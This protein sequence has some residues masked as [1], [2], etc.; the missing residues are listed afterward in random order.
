MNARTRNGSKI[1]R[2]R[3][4]VNQKPVRKVWDAHVVEFEADDISAVLYVD[5]HLM[6]E[7]LSLQ[8]FTAL[9][10]RNLKAR[11]PNRTF[12][13]LD[14]SKPTLPAVL[15]RGVAETAHRQRSATRTA[16]QLRQFDFDDYLDRRRTG[17][18]WRKRRVF[19]LL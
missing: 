13:T 8:A 16:P 19:K 14:H 7:V 9:A 17:G 12:A 11:R 18:S 1:W 10:E 6:N 2:R 3:E 5:L 4:D 15:H